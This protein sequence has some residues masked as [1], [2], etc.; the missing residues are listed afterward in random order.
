MVM[1]MNMLHSFAVSRLEAGWTLV[2]RGE[3]LLPTLMLV[4]ELQRMSLFAS[5][6]QHNDSRGR[7]VY[8]FRD[9]TT[10][11]HYVMVQSCNPGTRNIIAEGQFPIPIQQQTHR[12]DMFP[13]NLRIRAL[14]KSP[15]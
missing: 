7:R 6:E 11:K 4:G 10:S 13:A 15:D 5:F 9:F 12:H 2:Q 8:T 14:S 1:V 3:Q